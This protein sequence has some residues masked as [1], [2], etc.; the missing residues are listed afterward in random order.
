MV[1]L[2]VNITF[3]YYVLTSEDI[4]ATFSEQAVPLLLFIFIEIAAYSSIFL[5][6]KNSQREYRVKEENQKMLAERE[7]LQ[8]TTANMSERLKLMEKISAQNSRSAH[9]RRHINNMLLELLEQGDKYEAIA[10]LKKQDQNIPRINMVYC[11]NHVVNAS[12][13]HYAKLAEQSG[14]QTQIKLDIPG[15]LKVDSLE[16]SMVV[17]KLMENA[18]IA[19]LKQT[20]GMPL[21]INFICRN[22]GR[23]LLAMENPCAEDTKLDENGYPIANEEG[24]GVGSKSVIAFAK[25]Y[26]GELVYQIENRVFRVRLLI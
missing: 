25:K 7:Y 5:S 18:I 22:L 23:I 14:I 21:Y 10:L 11:E 4:I 9:D 19:C 15:E 8:I 13:C 12:V 1:A 26:D 16:L 6:L 3:T 2:G 24:Y 20:D 17:S